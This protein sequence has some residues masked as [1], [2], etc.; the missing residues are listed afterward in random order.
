M[1]VG[2]SVAAAGAVGGVGVTMRALTGCL[3]RRIRS[4]SSPHPMAGA[5]SAA[6]S[7]AMW[8]DSVTKLHLRKDPRVVKFVG[9]RAEGVSAEFGWQ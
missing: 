3:L 8:V 2:A 5:R 4:P 6:D 7:D 9:E 1:S